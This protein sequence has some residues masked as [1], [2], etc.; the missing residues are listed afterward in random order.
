MTAVLRV[1]GVHRHYR[2]AGRMVEAVS[3]VSL[4]IAPGETLGL[5]GASGSGKSTLARLVMA[6]ERP[7]RGRVMLDG[8]DL[9]TLPPRAL[10]RLRRRW[11][12][13]F[14]DPTAAFNPRATVAGAIADP[15]RIHRI[16]QPSARAGRIKALLG[17]VGLDPALATRPIRTLSGGQR[18]RVALARALATRP[19]LIVL[20]EAISA[21]DTRV[22]AQILHLL[23]D[24]QRKEGLAYLFISHDLAAVR[25]IA[26]RTAVMDAGRVVESGPTQA[27]IANPASAQ[28]QALVA[29]VPRL[30]LLAPLAVVERKAC[31]R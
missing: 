20:D 29:A 13:V 3:G 5:V 15:L 8:T 6:L 16:V 25:A 22:R 10:R 18:Q 9:A 7:D 21:L 26:H 30:D 4:G 17:R 28:A 2:R 12:M 19:A 23:I 31:T 1:E 14:Q 27:L 24:L 11:S